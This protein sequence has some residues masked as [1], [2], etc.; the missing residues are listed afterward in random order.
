MQYIPSISRY[1]NSYVVVMA[2]ITN[3]D[4]V[5]NA[6]MVFSINESEHNN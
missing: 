6:D 4:N 3:K 5:K 2:D 1:G